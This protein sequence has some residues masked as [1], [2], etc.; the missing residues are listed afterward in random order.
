MLKYKQYQQKLRKEWLKDEAFIDWITSSEAGKYK[1]H[2]QYS[3]CNLNSKYQDLKLCA[4][5]K[6]HKKSLPYKAVPLTT[7]FIKPGNS[8]AHNIEGCIAMFFSCH[9]AITNC[10]HM[11]DMLKHNISNCNTIDN[12]KMHRTKCTILLQM[13]HVLILKELTDNIGS[14][15][16]SLL[17]DECNDISVMKLL[18]VS[19]IYFSH[20]SNK[21]ESTYVGFA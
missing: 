3:I 17:L 21:L 2:C 7:S 15:K 9:C 14:N 10:D 18:G 20:A 19:I 5:C 16:F 13:C 4:E 1:T 12:A 11:V 8:E 6:R